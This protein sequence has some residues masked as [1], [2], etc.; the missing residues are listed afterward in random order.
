MEDILQAKEM[1]DK[2][3]DCLK[4]CCSDMANHYFS[5]AYDLLPSDADV[6]WKA[7]FPL[8]R[9]MAGFL[10]CHPRQANV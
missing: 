4:D 9:A 5:V 2:G 1:Y 10:L 8:W 6:E 7:D 3:L